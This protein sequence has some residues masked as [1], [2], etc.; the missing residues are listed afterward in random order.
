MIVL[1]GPAHGEVVLL[2]PQRRVMHNKNVYNL[3][4]DGYLAVFF[5][6]LS[7]VGVANYKFN[8]SCEYNQ[9]FP[10]TDMFPAEPLSATSALVLCVLAIFGPPVT[11]VELPLEFWLARA[12]VFACGVGSFIFHAI[13]DRHVVQYHTNR[14]I[15]DYV[16]MILIS[17]HTLM[18]YFATTTHAKIVLVYLYA[19]NVLFAVFSNDYLS[20]AW[21]WQQTDGAIS[22]AVQ[23]PVFV[24][25]YAPMSLFVL[26]SDAELRH[27]LPLFITTAVAIIAWILEHFACSA[28]TSLGHSIW[29]I[30]IGY[31]SILYICF[32]L[33]AR[34]FRVAGGWWPEV[35][36]A[37]EELVCLV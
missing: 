3:S 8:M 2:A 27:K 19:L 35:R 7:A 37:A 5:Y 22:W 9:L 12:S 25:P 34:G 11:D 26:R 30:F 4:V 21:L 24:M 17:M 29:H 6:G 36:P 33:R 16:T 10:N 31:A 32:G 18:L 1:E 28:A 23:Y 15:L 20:G 13:A 14:G